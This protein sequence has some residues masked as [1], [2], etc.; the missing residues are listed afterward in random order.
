MSERHQEGLAHLLYG[1]ASDSGGFIA[2]TGEVG[3]GKTTLCRCLLQQLPESVDI[4]LIF[5]PKLNALE[6]LAAICDELGVVY[7][8]GSAS[9]K[10][11]VDALNGYLL[12]AHSQGRRTVLLI[13]E[14]QNL[15]LEVLEQIRLLTNLE[16]TKTK[17]L[18]IILVGQPELKQLLEL[19]ELRQLNQR[20]TARYHLLPLS[21]AE[22]Q[23]YI[24]HRLTISQGDTDLFTP[25]AIRRIYR[26]SR[27][28]PRLINILCDRALLGAYASQ[29]KTIGTNI[30]NKAAQETLLPPK[31]RSTVTA[32]S[33]V[34]FALAIMIAYSVNLHQPVHNKVV[35]S[36]K[37]PQAPAETAVAA[38]I[39]PKAPQP[40][41]DILLA[42]SDLSLANAT[43]RL[44][45][46]WHKPVPDANAADCNLVQSG[47]LQCLFD[48]TDWQSLIALNRPAILELVSDAGDKRYLLLTG[49]SNERAI[50]QSEETITVPVLELLKHW[51]G[52]Y[53]V[54]WQPPRPGMTEIKPGERSANVRWLRHQLKA[55]NSGKPSDVFDDDLKK[56]VSDFQRQ[57]HLVADGLAGGRTLIHLDNLA[58]AP[59]SPKLSAASG[60]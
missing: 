35:L 25:A 8:T 6:L 26:L 3:T 30:V 28:I 21:F 39:A 38:T 27:G 9:L 11:L 29:Q 51:H 53:L 31:S 12:S 57:N 42:D 22:T 48:K 46:R 50:I 54:L 59:N 40:V 15:S 17:L 47:G 56:H 55:E 43:A 34:L 45:Q 23:A 33:L 44:L 41:L 5:N 2:L 36:G 52:Y 1:I 60:E 58:G 10:H 37:L 16:T 19:P 24:R 4:A 14:A 20:I 32:A 18:Q 7:Q 13:D 49:I